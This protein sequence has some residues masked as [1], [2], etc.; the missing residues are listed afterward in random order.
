MVGG[1]QRGQQLELRREHERDVELRPGDGER[2][3]GDE[4][5]LESALAAEDGGV[6]RARLRRPSSSGVDD[7]H[8]RWFIRTSCSLLML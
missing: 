5:Q 1:Q 3:G 6:G 4:R 7:S 8:D 2:R